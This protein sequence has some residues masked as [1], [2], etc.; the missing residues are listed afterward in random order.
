MLF[1]GQPP[2]DDGCDDVIHVEADLHALAAVARRIQ[3]VDRSL[4]VAAGHRGQ[5]EVSAAVGVELGALED[6][7]FDGKF[8]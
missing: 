3:R 7:S 5:R 6:V 2:V 8:V 4:L 1:H